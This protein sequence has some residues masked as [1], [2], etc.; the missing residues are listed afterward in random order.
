MTTSKEEGKRWFYVR[1]GQRH[2]PLEITR[3]VDLVLGGEVPEDAL[4]WHSGLPDWLPAREIEE[5][6]RELPPPLPSPPD[7]PPPDPIPIGA[8]EGPEADEAS[9]AVAW[10]EAGAP[11]EPSLEEDADGSSNGLKRRRKR[12]HRHRDSKRRPAWL[13]PLVVILVGLM[14]FLWW[15]LRRMNEVP[16][17]RIIQTGLLQTEPVPPVLSGASASRWAESRAS[18]PGSRA[19]RPA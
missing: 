2:G 18:A 7:S 15:L 16:P 4:V 11:D 1:E 3:L 6:R 5:I 14:I 9:D 8:A 10:Q 19:A 17:G 13:W 12:K